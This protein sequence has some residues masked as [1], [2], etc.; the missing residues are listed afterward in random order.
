[1][2]AL[3]RRLSRLLTFPVLAAAVTVA[4]PAFADKPRTAGIRVGEAQAR[5]MTIVRVGYGRA[6]PNSATIDVPF[7]VEDETWEGI[8]KKRNALQVSLQKA[9]E[10]YD[11]TGR[12]VDLASGQSGQTQRDS[13]RTTTYEG[14]FAVFVRDVSHLRAILARLNKGMSTP[15]TVRYRVVDA[16]AMAAARKSAQLDA[17]AEARREADIL[18]KAAGTRIIGIWELNE[19]EVKPIEA[20]PIPSSLPEQAAVPRE[21]DVISAQITIVF[22]MA[23]ALT[24]APRPARR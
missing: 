9:L 6:K 8:E 2:P 11:L 12:S 19:G 3:Q 4:L 18:A 20:Q 10:P 13:R 22:E 23:P 24:A 1:M 15:L 7:K 5:R 17:I 16:Q 14:S 21:I